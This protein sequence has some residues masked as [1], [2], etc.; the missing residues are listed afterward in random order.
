MQ[1]DFRNKANYKNKISSLSPTG[2]MSENPSTIYALLNFHKSQWN[3]SS[4]ENHTHKK[5]V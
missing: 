2:N 5:E 3:R 4:Q 1:I